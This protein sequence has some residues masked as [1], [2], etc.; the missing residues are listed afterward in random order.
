M[1]QAGANSTLAISRNSLLGKTYGASG[2]A[3]MKKRG[4]EARK[5]LK[6]ASVTQ[7][8]VPSPLL[9]RGLMQMPAV[10][11]KAK[12]VDLANRLQPLSARCFK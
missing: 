7:P 9:A 2:L 5:S 12:G 6:P 4:I 1:P 11:N 3:V 10:S 8:V